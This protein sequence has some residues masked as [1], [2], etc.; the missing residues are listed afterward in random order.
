M[1]FWH[2]S[3]HYLGYLKAY[4]RKTDNS[5]EPVSLTCLFIHRL[6]SDKN[7]LVFIH[8]PIANGIIAYQLTMLMIINVQFWVKLHCRFPEKDFSRFS[9]FR[10]L[11]I[12]F[13]TVSYV[14]LCSVCMCEIFNKCDS[15][16]ELNCFMCC[17]SGM[18]RNEK[19]ENLNDI[20]V[21]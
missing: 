13:P 14:K 6:C 19:T 8:A 10:K 17:V 2:I 4:V 20:I 12:D 3:V 15:E 5:S 16:F 18:N 11:I 7:A 21:N 1:D 9:N